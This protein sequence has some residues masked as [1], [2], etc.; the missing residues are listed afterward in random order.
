MEVSLKS[1]SILNWLTITAILSFAINGP[2]Q[3]NSWTKPTSGDR[4]EPFSS[5]GGIPCPDHEH[6]MVTTAGWKPLAI[7]RTTAQNYRDSLHIRR[8]TCA[9]PTSTLH[10]LLLNYVG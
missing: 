6:I 5:L 2:A 10:P 9:S 1:I 3:T 7:K 4:H 8:I